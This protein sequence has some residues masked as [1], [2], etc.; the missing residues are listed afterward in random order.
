MQDS[1]TVVLLC[2]DCPPTHE[3]LIVLNKRDVKCQGLD[4]LSWLG[5]IFGTVWDL[6]VLFSLLLDCNIGSNSNQISA[7]SELRLKDVTRDCYYTRRTCDRHPSDAFG[8]GNN[9]LRSAR[10]RDLQE[11]LQALQDSG[12]YSIGHEH[13]IRSM[14]LGEKSTCVANAFTNILYL[15]F[16]GY[17]RGR[18]S[19]SRALRRRHISRYFLTSCALFSNASMPCSVS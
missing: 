15:S 18:P 4:S 9:S 11:E 16:I 17:Y 7:H 10:W 8:T 14:Q 3:N 13:D 1:L 2:S 5:C 12:N 6:A 19:H